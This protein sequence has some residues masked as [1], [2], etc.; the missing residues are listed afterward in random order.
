M[1]DL[2][3]SVYKSALE[4]IHFGK[5]IGLEMVLPEVYEITRGVSVVRTS[6]SI[7]KFPRNVSDKL[8]VYKL[9]MFQ[10]GT[11]LT[12]DKIQKFR[13]K[14]STKSYNRLIEN[15]FI[16]IDA[17]DNAERSKIYGKLFTAHV[18]GKIN[19]SEYDEMAQ[20]TNSIP[21]TSLLELK[22]H[23]D[24]DFDTKGGRQLTFTIYGLLGF[25]D[26]T[27]N[28]IGGGGLIYPKTNLGWKY[29]GIIFDYPESK[30]DGIQIGKGELYPELTESGVVSDKAYPLE[31]LQSQSKRYLQI[32]LY[33]MDIDEEIVTENG[34]PKEICVLHPT[35]GQDQHELAV[36]V[37]NRSGVPNIR[38][39]VSVNF[40]FY[41][42]RAINSFLI[43]S[44]DLG[45]SLEKVNLIQLYDRLSNDQTIYI[46]EFE[47]LKNIIDYKNNSPEIIFD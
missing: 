21:L 8:L 26:S 40:K 43:V 15:L 12:S 3:I 18:N 25:S 36:R 14:I 28:T 20:I 10:Q 38:K 33:A 22:K 19:R 31:Y 1:L 11:D 4:K 24:L 27:I 6:I 7:L 35:I 42:N 45:N 9:S 37:A 32:K 30:I 39:I 2:A 16:A 44:N 17:H 34:L 41:G 46:E 47:L 29:T 13:K 23:Y 5:K